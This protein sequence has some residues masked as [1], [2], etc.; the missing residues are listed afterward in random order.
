MYINAN[1]IKI[2]FLSVSKYVNDSDDEYI[3]DYCKINYMMKI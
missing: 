1:K 3:N 2:N